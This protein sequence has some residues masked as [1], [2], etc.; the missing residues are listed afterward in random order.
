MSADPAVAAHHLVVLVEP[1]GA[2]SGCAEVGCRTG[3]QRVLGRAH[4]RTAAVRS[5]SRRI[6]VGI[7]IR[8][9]CDGRSVSQIEGE[10]EFPN[11]R[12]RRGNKRTGGMAGG[13]EARPPARLRL[14]GVDGQR[15]IVATARMCDVIGAT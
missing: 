12:W 14:I 5:S 10:R 3:K 8:A 9:L 7:V 2:N 1:G 4:G 6:H 13:K 11:D 15:L